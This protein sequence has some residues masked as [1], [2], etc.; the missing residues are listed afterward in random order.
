MGPAYTQ[1]LAVAAALQG[2]TVKE[3]LFQQTRNNQG[4]SLGSPGHCFECQQPG[5]SN[6]ALIP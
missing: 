1:G 5:L 2:K 6:L 4:K 3:V